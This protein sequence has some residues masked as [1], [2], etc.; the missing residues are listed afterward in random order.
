MEVPWCGPHS[1]IYIYSAMYVLQ[2]FLLFAPFPKVEGLSS[3]PDTAYLVFCLAI[4]PSCV[5]G[6][7]SFLSAVLCAFLVN[8]I[9]NIK[10]IPSQFYMFVSFVLLLPSDSSRGASRRQDSAVLEQGS[11]RNGWA[12]RP[13]LLLEGA[14]DVT[15]ALV[16]IK[17]PGKYTSWRLLPFQNLAET[18]KIAGRDAWCEH[19]H[20][21]SYCKW[22]LGSWHSI[23][24]T[25]EAVVRTVGLAVILEILRALC[26]TWRE[27][28]ACSSHGDEVLPVVIRLPWWQ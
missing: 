20:L 21:T 2:N 26:K 3:I 22:F 19:M 1:Y 14:L 24:Y 5:F 13:V 10:L 11:A 12:D 6:G 17:L 9:V 8:Y 25:L 7:I 18:G 16:L 15:Q 28:G 27:S 4:H 23:N